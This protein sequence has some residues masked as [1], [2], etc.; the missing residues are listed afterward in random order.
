TFPHDYQFIGT[1]SSIYRQIG[2]AVPCDLAQVVAE[3]VRN[4]L[5]KGE[6]VTSLPHLEREAKQLRLAI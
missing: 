1:Q 4:S 3:V 6:V 5:S 2:N